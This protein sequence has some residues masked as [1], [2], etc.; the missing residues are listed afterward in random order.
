MSMS[1]TAP[2]A[3][4]LDR[5]QHHLLHQIA[6]RILVAK[7]AQPVEADAWSEAAIQLGLGRVRRSGTG[8]DRAR[9]IAVGRADD[10]ARSSSR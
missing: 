4:L 1:R 8:G 6:R 3:Q 2:L 10:V 7:M 5:Q 9:E